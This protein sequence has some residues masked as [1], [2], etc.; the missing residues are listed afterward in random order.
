VNIDRRPGIG[1]PVSPVLGD[2]SDMQMEIAILPG[3]TSGAEFEPFFSNHFYLAKDY[4]SLYD[5]LPYKQLLYP[6]I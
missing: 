3:P 2:P 6:K 5:S 1:R 4:L